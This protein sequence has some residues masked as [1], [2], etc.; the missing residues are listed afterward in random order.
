MSRG[1]CV[2][3]ENGLVCFS[4]I[5]EL[6]N[7]FGSDRILFSSTSLKYLLKEIFFF[8]KDEFQS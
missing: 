7:A 4:D 2:V 3:E 8:G 5:L 1:K 6:E